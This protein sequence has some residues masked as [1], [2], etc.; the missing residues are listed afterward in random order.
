[1]LGFEEKQLMVDVWENAADALGRAVRAAE[2][3][4]RRDIETVRAE[5]EAADAV[6]I[7]GPEVI[8]ALRTLSRR[9]VR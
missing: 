8:K 7:R 5:P 9:F 1:M 6:V 2:Q 3:L 4:E